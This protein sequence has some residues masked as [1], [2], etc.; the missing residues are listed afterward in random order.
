M[1]LYELSFA[2]G[3]D[4]LSVRHFSVH[5]ELSTPFVVEVLARSPHDDLDLE[6]IT[7]KAAA[8]RLG[9]GLKFAQRGTRRWGGVCR[10]MQLVQA[11]GTGL[12]TYMLHL[13]PT[14]W[15]LG[16]RTGHRLF[17]HLSIPDIVARVLGEWRVE[18]TFHVDRA[19]HPVLELRVQYGESD[20]A[21]VHRLLEEAGI[22]YYFTDEE[23]GPSR[24][25]F[26]DRPQ[27][28]QPRP[29]P[30]LPYVDNPNEAS[31]K[32]FVTR[33]RLSHEVRPG[34]HT[35]RD[36]DF[37][38]ATDYRLFG[39][40]KPAPPPEDGLE[41]YHYA[42]G[43]FLVEGAKG[44]ETPVADDRGT[45]RYVDREGQALAE[46][47]LE[48][49]RATKRVVDFE[50]NALDLAPGVVF[51]IHHPRPDLDASK[52]LLAIALVTSG[53]PGEEWTT[54]GRAAFAE[55]PWRPARVTPR[56]AIH[57]VQSAIVV[58]PAGEEIH[59]DEFGRVRVQFPWDREGTYNERSSCW[60]RV[61]QGWA[62]QAYGLV[63]IPRIGHE[64][65]ISFLDGNP[66]QPVL[67]GRL[68]NNPTKVPY[69]LPR[70]KTRSTW[71]SDSSP[72]SGGFNELMFEDLAGEE[73]VYV[74]AQK[75]LK[76]LVKHDEAITVG[77]TRQKLVKLD[78]LERT[79]RDRRITVDR[80][81]NQLVKQDETE[82]TLRDRRS[83]V[84]QDEHLVIQRD[85]RERVERDSHEHVKGDRCE[86]V[87]GVV[88]V[89][90]GERREEKIGQRHGLEVGE[91]IHLRAGMRVIIEAGVRLTLR[92]PG[93]FIDIN[94]EGVT[95]RG[96]LVRI[97]SGGSAG[98]GGGAHPTLPDEAE[99]A[100]PGDPE[101]E[102]VFR[103]DHE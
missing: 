12:S 4:S 19:C 44:G 15:M 97:N 47:S 7:G 50:T 23:S 56:P 96:N 78:E 13:V 40:A 98:A 51:A 20:L 38:R 73:L 37:R 41:Q 32:E 103:R 68:H 67:V 80:D 6:A 9:S 81:L 5:E 54:S 100:E 101:L 18:H 17:Q 8:F 24:L 85:R 72:G 79:N 16:Q 28:A 57:G 26:H 1:A 36:Y 31:E 42:P 43:S 49:Q 10:G 39:E 27:I 29:G 3:E 46:R 76:K 14:L 34:R 70:R 48:A 52:H 99:V 33:V 53:A 35:L 71:K 102:D 75:D 60:V 66:D 30:P 89:V 93:G 82:R 92:G 62:G 90:I 59:T 25:V 87:D 2:S 22:A 95:I 11:E 91:E 69:K 61:S 45:A 77:Q 58:G 83:T 88:S 86:K 63:A 84:G 64:V 21:F 55:Q 94:D 74:Q 65:L